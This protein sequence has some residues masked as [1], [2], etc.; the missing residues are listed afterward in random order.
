MLFWGSLRKPCIE[1]GH[2]YNLALCGDPLNIYIGVHVKVRYPIL[3]LSV[4][5]HGSF[6]IVIVLI[7]NMS[8]RL[9]TNVLCPQCSAP[10]PQHGDLPLRTGHFPL[11]DMT[12]RESSYLPERIKVFRDD[13][14]NTVGYLGDPDVAHDFEWMPIGEDN[15]LVSKEA[16][17]EF[18]ASQATTSSSCVL[19]P[20]PV[21][22]SAIMEI[23]DD[24]FRFTSC[25]MWRGGNHSNPKNFADV[26]LTCLG[27]APPHPPLT[28]DYD[29]VLLNLGKIIRRQSTSS[30]T[31]G[32]FV[33][34]RFGGHTIRLRHK[35]FTELQPGCSEAVVGEWYCVT[36]VFT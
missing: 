17:A 3:V 19:G 31:R 9:L 5:S 24:D 26:Y 36:F 25:G 7:A 15:W 16:A 10:P 22:L 32:I 6:H 12:S 23:S 21:Q 20:S 13:L 8:F 1:A 29:N 27:D 4:T 2:R 18:R 33:T 35:L 34:S 11:P 30:V 28:A 14:M